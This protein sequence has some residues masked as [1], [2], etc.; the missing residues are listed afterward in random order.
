MIESM[1]SLV[2]KQSES[3]LTSVADTPKNRTC[4]KLIPFK[5]NIKK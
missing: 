3:V 1:H 2:A 4:Q 5:V